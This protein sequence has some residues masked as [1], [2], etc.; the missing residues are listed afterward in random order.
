[1]DQSQEKK[2][3]PEVPAAVL[4]LTAQNCPYLELTASS[5]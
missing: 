4:F 5:L 2:F 1:M 3:A